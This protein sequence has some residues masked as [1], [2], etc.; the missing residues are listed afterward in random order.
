[1]A[2]GTL[3][4]SSV[5]PNRASARSRKQ[6]EY[7]ES[8]IAMAFDVAVAEKCYTVASGWVRKSWSVK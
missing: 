3:F 8:D 4:N 6:Q 1:M 7:T 5:Y 2:R